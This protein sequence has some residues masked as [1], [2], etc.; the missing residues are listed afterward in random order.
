MKQS[1]LDQIDNKLAS[2]SKDQSQVYMLGSALL[3]AFLVY[4][5]AFPPAE[6]FF[7]EKQSALD[8]VTADLANVDSYLMQNN[9]ATVAKSQS[10][11][12]Q[13]ISRLNSLVT[14]NNYID[15]KLIELSQITYN[16]QNW[17]KFL[18]SLTRSAKENDIKVLSIASKTLEGNLTGVRPMLDVNISMNGGF[19]SVLKY[20]NDIE[21]SEMVVDVNGLDINS[22]D[23]DSDL[24]GG[25]IKISVWGIKH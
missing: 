14:Q 11:L 23:K 24:I 12:N 19:H 20:I 18:D 22:T 16:E 4:L 21:E 6:E 10:E 25:N 7:N 3:I 8:K 15:K 13:K 5:I 2:G 1:I 17:A 9:E